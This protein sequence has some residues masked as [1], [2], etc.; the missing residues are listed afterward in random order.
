MANRKSRRRFLG[1]LT[2]VAVFGCDL[3]PHRKDETK[4]KAADPSKPEVHSMN[5][6]D[7]KS[8]HRNNRLSG[9]LSDQAREI[10]SHFNIQ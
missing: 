5:M 3:L 10:E 9:G 1:T 7:A 4:E 8:F 6:D 2:L